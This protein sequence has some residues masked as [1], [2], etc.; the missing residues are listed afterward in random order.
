MDFTK[1]IN[2]LNSLY[3]TFRKDWKFFNDSQIDA[4]KENTQAKVKNLNFSRH[5][6]IATQ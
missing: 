5:I 3:D 1:L 2:Y 4:I 6:K